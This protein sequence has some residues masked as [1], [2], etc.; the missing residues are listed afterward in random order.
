[1]KT[2]LAFVFLVLLNSCQLVNFVRYGDGWKPKPLSNVSDF[3]DYV[4]HDTVH[5]DTL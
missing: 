2:I 4:I 3:E 5:D 1:M